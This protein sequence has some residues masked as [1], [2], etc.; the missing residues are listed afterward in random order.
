MKR[1]FK[2]CRINNSANINKTNHVSVK[3]MNAGMV[4]NL[5]IPDFLESSCS[6]SFY[7]CCVLPLFI[8]LLFFI[9][10]STF[11]KIEYLYETR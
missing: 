9:F 6:Q 2:Q 10:E 8:M 11:A 7:F 3:A 4:L 5:L 1:K